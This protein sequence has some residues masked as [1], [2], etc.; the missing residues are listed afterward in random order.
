[1]SDFVLEDFLK[2]QK[3]LV[4]VWYNTFQTENKQ[5]PDTQKLME[6]VIDQMDTVL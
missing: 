3:T 1:M 6:L 5:I 2:E 4:T